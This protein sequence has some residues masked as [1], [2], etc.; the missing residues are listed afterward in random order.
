MIALASAMVVSCD[1]VP[2]NGDLDGMWQLMKID[3]PSGCRETKSDRAY[4]SIQLHLSQW[5]HSSDIYYAHFRREGDSIFFYDFCHHSLHRSTADDNE[6]ITYEEMTTTKIMDAWGI[7]N[8]DARY[9]VQELNSDAL[10]L[11]K[12]DTTLTFRKF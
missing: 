2:M 10:V 7:H 11:Q 9:R 8:L 3:T 6:P 4:M 5:N 1:K 12:E